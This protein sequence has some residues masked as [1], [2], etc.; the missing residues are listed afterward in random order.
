MIQQ[1]RYESFRIVLFKIKVVMKYYWNICCQYVSKKY[2]FY[3]VNDIFM[4][5]V[6]RNS[7]D[8]QFFKKWCQYEETTKYNIY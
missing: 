6:I 7:Y 1:D 4:A 8:F 5:K 3:S 2:E